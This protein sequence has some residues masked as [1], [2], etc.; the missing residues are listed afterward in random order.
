MGPRHNILHDPPNDDDLELL[1]SACIPIVKEVRKLN[2]HVYYPVFL[3][4]D[5]R[6]VCPWCFKVSSRRLRTIPRLLAD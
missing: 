1:R 3:P 4:F 2:G 6:V 5:A